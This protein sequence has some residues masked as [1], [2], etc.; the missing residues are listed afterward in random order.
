MRDPLKKRFLW[1]SNLFVLPDGRRIHPLLIFAPVL[2][3]LGVFALHLYRE[4]RVHPTVT[5]SFDVSVIETGLETATPVAEPTVPKPSPEQ[6][7]APKPVAAVNPT[8][9][10]TIK[11]LP[12][13]VKPVAAPTSLPNA[14]VYSVKL[15][16]GRQMDFVNRALQK[17]KQDNHNA[18][19]QKMGDQYWILIGRFND[20]T[21]AQSQLK[22]ITAS[23]KYKGEIVTLSKAYRQ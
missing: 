4:S 18:F 5:T 9:S 15:G 7:V 1:V 14:T 3:I 17:L 11:P 12:E 20:P 10:L 21:A 16:Q 13:P 19:Y 22:S 23:G 2:V 6:P 8:P